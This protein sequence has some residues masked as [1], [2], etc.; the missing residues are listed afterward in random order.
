MLLAGPSC[1]ACLEYYEIMDPEP[2]NPLATRPLCTFL[3]P[4]YDTPRKHIMVSANVE[5]ALAK[6]A[7]IRAS[8]GSRQSSLAC[9]YHF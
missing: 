9:R 5:A 1:S 2:W 3:H 4:L 6:A 7:K 8:I